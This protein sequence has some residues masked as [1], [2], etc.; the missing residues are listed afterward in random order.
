MQLNNKYE[1]ELKHLDS[2]Q[3]IIY[4]IFFFGRSWLV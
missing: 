1:A 3:V 4:L 2:G